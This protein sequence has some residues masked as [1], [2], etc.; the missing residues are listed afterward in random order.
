MIFASFTANGRSG[1]GLI[2]HDEIMEFGAVGG[3]YPTLGDALR[4]GI[5]LRLEEFDP[6]RGPR[7]RLDDV[8]LLPPVTDPGKILCVGLNYEQHEQEMRRER[9]EQ[10]TVFT[11]F[12]DTF[13]GTGSPLIAPAAS[14]TFDYEGELAVVIGGTARRIDPARAHRVIAGYT[15]INDGSI[16][17]YQRHS[18]QWTPG[19]NFPATG[20][21][22]PWLVTPD[23]IADFDAETL[24]TRLNGEIVQKA[25][26]RDLIWSVSELIAYISEWTELRPGDIIATG[27]PGGVGMA[28]DPQLWMKPGDTVDVSI[29]AIGRLT[30]TV[31]A[32]EV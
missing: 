22:G 32:E 25:P 12:A 17:A 28:R 8:T 1:W 24:T 23:E 31:V 20:S 2:E 3:P 14:E 18:T 21:M 26:L 15:L 5:A 29:P 27:T 10:P 30:N 4:S 11:R 16:R 9:P 19:K 13:V 7:Y 6:V